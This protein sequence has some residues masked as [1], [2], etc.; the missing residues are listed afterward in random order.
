[1]ELNVLDS[2]IL[3]EKDTNGD[4]LAIWSYPSVT[5]EE[6][7]V[8]KDRSNLGSDEIELSFSFSKFHSKWQHFRTQ[9]ITEA[10]N[11]VLPRTVA[12][13]IVLTSKHFDP[14][15]YSAIS[16]VLANK[17]AETGETISI[18]TGFLSIFR[19]GNFGKFVLSD[20]SDQRKAFFAYSIKEVI[21]M[22]GLEVILLWV[23]MLLK[24]RVVVY[25]DRLSAL[26]NVVRTTPLFVW[27][28]QNWGLLR[29]YVTVSDVELNDLKQC[30]TFVAGFTDQ[31]IKTN[32]QLYDVFVDIPSQSITVADHAKGDFVLGSYH[33]EIAMLLT[34][35]AEN[36]EQTDQQLV[37]AITQ[38]TREL[39]TNIKSLAENDLITMEILKSKKLAQ[40]MDKFLYQ[41]ALCE[42]LSVS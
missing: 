31:Q 38:K 30:G 9:L 4:V 17:Y 13:T 21:K 19:S 24:K 33:K 1:M 40:S 25:S 41:V 36:D 35:S 28:R 10:S 27:H 16:K 39:V 7:A 6:E 32:E 23:A 15:R 14:E 18:L 26:M 20:F 22:F 29:P 42:G 37:K 2:V 34:K 8:M 5:S 12:F 11:K 3:L